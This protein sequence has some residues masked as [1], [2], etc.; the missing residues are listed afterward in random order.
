VI[1]I[2]QSV[3]EISVKGVDVV[4]AR[5]IREHLAQSLRNRLLGKFDLSHTARKVYNDEVSK[6]VIYIYGQKMD[7]NL[8]ERANTSDLVARMN[9]GRSPSLRP[10]EDDINELRARRDRLHR[11]EVVDRHVSRVDFNDEVVKEPESDSTEQVHFKRRSLLMKK[12]SVSILES[13]TQ[14]LF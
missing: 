2:V 11:F 1:T 13:R 6:G 3:A 10:H 14:E 9:D 4:Q 5:E 7:L 12:V 8:L